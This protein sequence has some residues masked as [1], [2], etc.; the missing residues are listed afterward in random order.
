[1]KDLTNNDKKVINEYLDSILN[2]NLDEN[3]VKEQLL[4]YL[5]KWSDYKFT[6]Q[7]LGKIFLL[8]NAPDSDGFSNEITINELTQYHPSFRTSNGG[9]WCRSDSSTLGKEYI[10]RRIKDGGRISSVKL[11]GFNKGLTIKQVIRKDISDSIKKKRCVILDVGKVEVDHKNG[12]KDEHYMNDPS[13]QSLNDFQPLS[14]AANDAKREHC[15]KCK[16]TGKRYDAKNLGYS[17]SFTKGDFFTDNCQGCYWY[18]P[19]KFNQ[20]I[21]ANFIKT[22]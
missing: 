6:P 9:D 11:D 1:M 3:I 8:V 19:I 16:K 7:L 14:K 2:N 5:E 10:I 18:D 22:K 13:A 4:S 17:E 20:E 12:K 21:S 15:K